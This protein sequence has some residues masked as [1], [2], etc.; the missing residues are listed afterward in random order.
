MPIRESCD[1]DFAATSEPVSLGRAVPDAGMGVP[2]LGRRDV[3]E[4]QS[5]SATK[6]IE[7]SQGESLGGVVRFEFA[8]V[9]SPFSWTLGCPA[10]RTGP[11]LWSLHLSDSAPFDIYC[12]AF[13]S[14]ARA[15]LA[16][17]RKD[18]VTFVID[19][20]SQ[21]IVTIRARS[22]LSD[23][24]IRTDDWQMAAVLS[25]LYHDPAT[26][27]P[28]LPVRSVPAFFTKRQSTFLR[29][30]LADQMPT[31]IVLAGVPRGTEDEILWGVPKLGSVELYDNLEQLYQ[32][33]PT[34]DAVQCPP[35]DMAA[36]LLL[37]R[38]TGK[39]L[40]LK[41]CQGLIPLARTTP[42]LPLGPRW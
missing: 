28:V 23:T 42:A 3:M 2:L 37:A 36:G 29:Q 39:G 26:Y 11:D 27:L 18:P 14:E 21:V 32:K 31:R 9:S 8:N 17:A 34:E 41:E 6:R 35:R 33:F 12:T 19:R 5:L 25:S 13:S 40:V 30:C 7:V 38:R 16:L 15:P 1:V 10:E 4:L 20:P 24:C 22:L